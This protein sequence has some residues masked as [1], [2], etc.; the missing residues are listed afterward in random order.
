MTDRL[1]GAQR[2]ARLL[3]QDARVT[4]RALRRSPVYT[5]SAVLLMIVGIGATTATYSVIDA[6]LLRP[7][8]LPSPQQLVT[9]EN[10]DVPYD[11]GP[12]FPKP[13]AYVSDL[14]DLGVFTA[15]AADALGAL[16]LGGAGE[17][18][19]ASVAYVTTGFF[20]AMGRAPAL[21]RAFTSL[22][23]TNGGSWHVAIL[24]HRFWMQR[25]G[26]SRQIL[27][28]SFTLNKREYRVVGVMPADFTFPSFPDLWLPFPLPIS[29]S[30]VFE[31]FGRYIPTHTVAR[32]RPGVSVRMADEAVARLESEY[33]TWSYMA[34]SARVLVKPMQSALLSSNVRDAVVALGAAAALVLVLASLNLAGLLSARG[35]RR[36]QELGVRIALGASRADIVRLFLVEALLLSVAGAAGGVLVALFSMPTLDALLPPQLLAIARPTLDL[37]LL[38]FAIGVSVL[39]TAVVTVGFGGRVRRE[40]ALGLGMNGRPVRF[41]RA[42]ALRSLLS[43]IQIGLALVL[44]T[45][46]ALMVRTFHNLASVDTG[47]NL[48]GAAV[49]QV[50]LA[51]AAYPSGSAVTTFVQSTLKRLASAPGVQSAGAVDVLPIAGHGAFAEAVTTPSAR[52]DTLLPL[53]YAVTPGYFGSLGIPLLAGRDFHWSDQPYGALIVNAAVAKRLWPDEDPIGQEVAV[54]GRVRDVIGVVGNVRTQRLSEE[55]LPQVYVPFAEVP[56]RT[57]SIVV[58][59]GLP[60]SAIGSRIREAV[61][62]VDPEEPLY[63][64]HWVEDLVVATISDERSAGVLLTA[65]GIIALVL[66][67]IGVYSVTAY[68][69]EGRRREFA[70]RVAV[71]AHPNDVLVRIVRRTLVL[72]LFGVGLGVAMVIAAQRLLSSVIQ[73]IPPLGAREVGVAATAL[74]T[75]VLL[76]SIN[77]TIRAV[78]APPVDAFR[79]D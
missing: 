28:R 58:R 25:F 79:N 41:R 70:I 13:R 38:V 63:G 20:R 59:S 55:A 53:M 60:L 51:P 6:A 75:A 22:E 15:V 50:S 45:A 7:L 69:I 71:G 62:A 67:T 5:A 8:A 36:R 29:N 21:G 32:L 72:G 73:G 35:M 74:L 26:G 42:V 2:H 17:A 48:A 14:Q 46:A 77:P 54:G 34:D 47:M 64:V 52:A 18:S 30:Q 78:R 19:R 10:A 49:G 23:G 43:T 57:V 33:P 76:A 4:L 39:V 16:N 9:I 11:F 31:A 61:K 1:R 12:R 3:V 56:A 44:V 66:A 27:G 24:S 40:S 65:F 68:G 37:R